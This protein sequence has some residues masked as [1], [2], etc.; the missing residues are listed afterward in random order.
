MAPTPAAPRPSDPTRRLVVIRHARAEQVANSDAERRLTS[1]GRA[2]AVAAGRWLRD[3]GLEPD[4]LLVSSAERT[5]ETAAGVLEG[6]RFVGATLDVEPTLYSASPETALDLVRECPDDIA[7]LVVIGHNPTMA[8]LAQLL[9]D[10]EGDAQASAALLQ[11]YPTCT[12]T[13]FDVE[14]AWADL[15]EQQAAVVAYQVARG[16]G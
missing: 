16:A 5:R 14:G 3:R 12:M 10:G 9:D 4:R 15:G 2:D 1:E 6:G 13:V 7:T 11:G 8:Y